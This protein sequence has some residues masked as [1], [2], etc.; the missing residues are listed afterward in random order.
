MSWLKILSLKFLICSTIL[1]GLLLP[2]VLSGRPAPALAD[3]RGLAVRKVATADGRTMDLYNQSRALL[4]GVSDYKGGW[5]RLE[6]IPAE[7]DRVK[8]ALTNQG[9]EVVTVMNPDARQLRQAF[10]NFIYEYGYQEKNR[11]LFYYAGHGYTM[12]EG[13]KGYLVPVDAPDPRKKAVDFKRKA[14]DMNL[15]LAWC[16]QMEARHA[17]F[18]FDSCFSGTIFKQ[19]DL[20]EMPPAIS[21]LTARPVRQF[22]TA[23]S[24]GETVPA[25]STF[26]PAFIDAL[27]HGLGDLNDD[28]YVSGT[29]LG[30]YLQD[31][32]PRHVGQTPQYG[33]IRDYD[34]SRGDFIFLAGGSTVVTKPDR[35][36]DKSDKGTLKIRTNPQGADIYV[37]DRHKGPSPVSLSDL[38]PDRYQVRAEKEGY[39]DQ[40]KQVRV[41]PGRIARVGLYL[42]KAARTARLYV[43]PTPTDSRVRI[44]N[45]KKDYHPG[46][47]LTP[48]Q[49]QIRVEKEGYETARRSEELRAGEDLDLYVD[50]PSA[51]DHQQ[52]QK[53]SDMTGKKPGQGIR[54]QPARATWTTGH[55]QAALYSRALEDLG[56]TVKSPQKMSSPIFYRN[57]AQ[58]RVDFWANGWFPLHEEFLPEDWEGTI[59]LAGTVTR[60]GALQGYLVSR[61]HAQRYNITS[62]DDFKRPEVKA[63][64]DENGDGKADLVA[65]PSGWGCEKTISFH[66]DVYGLER[67]INPCRTGYSAAMTEALSRYRDGEPVFFYTWTPSWTIHQLKPGRDVVWINVPEIIPKP[68]QKGLTQAMTARDVT[69][70]VTDPCKMGFVVNDLRV[71]ANREFLEKNPAAKK[72]F[73]LMSLPLDDIVAQNNKMFQ[74]EDDPDDIEKHV[75]QWIQK[76]RDQ[77]QDWLS[78]AAAAAD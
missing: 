19:R 22:I 46:I 78:A 34:L 77:W 38:Q 18:L 35:E 45:I 40:V 10:N 9:F 66:L 47:E 11:L 64:F 25:K 41:R 56:Y 1:A 30:L 43:H 63:A 29:E 74:G 67:H 36:A 21:R 51:P 48:G 16:R 6:R 75:D 65:C 53:R 27:T 15:I 33:K 23:G 61:E 32:V 14:L 70:T 52:P 39:L 57:L 5:P 7:M 26:T 2:V 13:Q 24:A 44:M 17:L 4:V 12:G 62:L 76:H 42:E 50:L 59:S 69:G 20:P 8:K 28:G 60:G 71:V 55:F 68:D 37:N 54:V 73:A 3:N 31:E 58:G 72:M 49:Y